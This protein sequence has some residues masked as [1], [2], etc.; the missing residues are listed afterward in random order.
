MKKEYKAVKPTDAQ[1][2]LMCRAYDLRVNHGADGIYP[3]GGQHRAL[4]TL[5]RFG[6]MRFVGAGQCIDGERENDQ[7]IWEITEKGE[8][9]LIA[10]G[11]I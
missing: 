3:I 10:I 4:R 8:A 2:R 5:E 1:V 6:F 7:P 9:Y 11:E